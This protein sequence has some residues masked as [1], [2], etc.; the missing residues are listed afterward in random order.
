MR[1][2][3]PSIQTASSGPEVQGFLGASTTHS[4]SG[5]GVGEEGAERGV[6][7]MGFFSATPNISNSWRQPSSMRDARHWQSSCTTLHSTPGGV[8]DCTVHLWR[9]IA[10]VTVSLLP[11][12]LVVTGPVKFFSVEELPPSQ[13]LQAGWGNLPYIFLYLCDGYLEGC[14]L[15]M[16]QVLDHG[17]LGCQNRH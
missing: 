7:T 16:G 6:G 15:L 9:A 10:R 5:S 17:S 14:G 13:Y 2:N 11:H 4:S 3:P 1:V 8:P 12:F